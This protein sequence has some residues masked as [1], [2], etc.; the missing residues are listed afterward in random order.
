MH[1]RMLSFFTSSPE[2]SLKRFK[3]AR[4]S[5]KLLL[6]CSKAAK[7]TKPT[8]LRMVKL[9]LLAVVGSEGNRDD[10][11]VPASNTPLDHGNLKLTRGGNRPASSANCQAVFPCA[12]S[13]VCRSIERL[14]YR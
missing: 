4:S 6:Y 13:P 3:S 12:I 9:L 8:A 1:F 5:L 10:F 2:I 14:R 11:R 7:A